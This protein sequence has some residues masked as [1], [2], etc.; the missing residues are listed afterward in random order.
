MKVA[1]AA[2]D[3]VAAGYDA[4]W[5]NTAAGRAQRDLVWSN[6]DPILQGSIVDIGCGTGED[7]AHFAA[8][9]IRVHA[10]DASPEMVRQAS[11][12]GGF[13]V[14]VGRAEDLTGEYDGAIS[15]FGALNCIEDLGAVARRVALAVRPGG[16]VAICTIGRFCLWETLYYTLRLQWGKAWRRARGTADSSFGRVNY[17]TMAALRAAFAEDF[18]CER[19]TGVGL[20]VPPSYVR[21]PGSMIAG[22]AAV[23]RLLAGIPVLRGMADHRLVLLVRR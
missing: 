21:L 6:V 22:C 18:R 23:D 17:P 15:N 4:A 20:L 9:G 3:R 12:R 7:A 14:E 10:I 19:W 2:F 1:A 5:T 8:L 13:T 11:R 16:Y